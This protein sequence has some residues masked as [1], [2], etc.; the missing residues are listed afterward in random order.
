[1]RMPYPRARFYV[2]LVMA[3]IA[4]GFW[5]SYFAIWDSVPWQFHAHGVAAS[6]WV[7]MVF[8]Q[9]WTAHHRLPL[10]RAVGQSSLLL[11]PF[12]TGVL[13][14]TS[15]VRAQGHYPTDHPVTG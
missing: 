1:M 8:A 14:A 10:E 9:I 15:D 11:F 13:A 3:V 6:I 2:L 7:M 5:P 4:A 12:L